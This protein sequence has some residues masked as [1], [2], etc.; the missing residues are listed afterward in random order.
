MA[1]T[2]QEQKRLDALMSE[3]MDIEFELIDGLRTI[4][5]AK[6]DAPTLK[7]DVEEKLEQLNKLDEEKWPLFEKD[8]E[9]KKESKVD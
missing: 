5:A 1:L 7:K 3:S 8:D 4:V 6:W 9:G 2:A